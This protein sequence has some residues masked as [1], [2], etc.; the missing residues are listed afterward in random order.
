MVRRN[1]VEPR[2]IRIPR[3]FTLGWNDVHH[4]ELYVS[5]S[6]FTRMSAGDFQDFIIQVFCCDSFFCCNIVVLP[7][8][9][10]FAYTSD[11]GFL[12]G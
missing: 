3:L 9:N 8:L 4:M 1:I 10:Y 6:S 2:L 5:R 11:K 7:T 12:V